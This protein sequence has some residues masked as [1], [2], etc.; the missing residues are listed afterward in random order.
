VNVT[1]NWNELTLHNV[2]IEDT[3][4]YSCRGIIRNSR[5]VKFSV[6]VKGKGTLLSFIISL[7]INIILLSETGI[8]EKGLR[9]DANTAR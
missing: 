6:T 8:N 4:V 5:T 9:G 3:G 2:T 7:T 1:A